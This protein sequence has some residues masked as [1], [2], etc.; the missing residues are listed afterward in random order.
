VTGVPAASDV[1]VLAPLT[2]GGSIAV[3]RAAL[4]A[5][6]HGWSLRLLHV[7]RDPNRIPAAEAALAQL[8][9]QLHERLGVAVDTQ[10]TGG[11]LLKQ[12]MQQMA[13]CRLLVIGSSH[14]D[15]L[16]RKIEG[17]ALER[18]VRLSRVPTLLV[19]RGVDAAFAQGAAQTGSHGRYARVL[20][21]V[22][23]DGAACATVDAARAI[24]PGARLEAFHAVSAKASGGRRDEAPDAGPPAVLERARSALAH[25]LAAE[26]R[27]TALPWVGFGDPADAVLARQ[28]ASGADLVVIGKRQRGLLADFFLGR[29]TRHVLAGSN[30]D[31]LVLPAARRAA[32]AAPVDAPGAPARLDAA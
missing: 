12:V 27:D 25:L 21:S 15:V 5:S 17:V 24:A 7:E 32:S 9:R 28:R 16:R 19:K 11:D 3:R 4:L 6:E 14:D 20:A 1:L 8:A 22:D 10:V 30:S 31:V 23:L 18:L 26:G 13:T 29:V 2:T